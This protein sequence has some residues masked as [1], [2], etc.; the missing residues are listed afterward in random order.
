VE[1]VTGGRSRS[2]KV[3]F[4]FLKGLA[5][6]L[7]L[8]VALDVNIRRANALDGR[9]DQFRH[10]YATGGFLL[11]LTLAFALW[12]VVQH[13]IR[14]RHGYPP[15]IALIAIAISLLFAA[16]DVVRSDEVHAD[17]PLATAAAVPAECKVGAQPYGDP[18]AGLRYAEA[19]GADRKQAL[20]TGSLGSREAG[21]DVSFALEG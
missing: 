18:P 14:M 20:S 8:L 16:T 21:T 9:D 15:W 11:A 3:L 7:L 2:E 13:A 1:T 17:T 5:W 19:T 4:G 10:G 6:L 12:F